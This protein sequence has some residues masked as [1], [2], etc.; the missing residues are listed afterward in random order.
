M[1]TFDELINQAMDPNNVDKL[2]D[3]FA[4]INKEYIL[5]LNVIGCCI[6]VHSSCC[7]SLFIGRDQSQRLEN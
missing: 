3:I 6:E 1:G 2:A 4:D 5:L 7:Y